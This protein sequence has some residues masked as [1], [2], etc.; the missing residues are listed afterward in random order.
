MYVMTY[1]SVLS[2]GKTVWNA[3]YT[4]WYGER[5]LSKSTGGD[6][7]VDMATDIDTYDN[8]ATRHSLKEAPRRLTVE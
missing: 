3:K 1:L 8:T 7:T 6:M 5:R 2:S 4:A